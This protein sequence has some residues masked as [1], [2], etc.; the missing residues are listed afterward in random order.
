M[1]AGA[2]E[3]IKIARP[4]R[5]QNDR[6]HYGRDLTL[7]DVDRA[8]R[9]AA[10]GNML[11]IT[12][13]GRE[14]LRLDASTSGM[15]NKRLNRAGAIGWSVVANDGSGR[16]EYDHGRAKARA[17]FVRA[18]LLNIPH[19][20]ERLNDLRWSTW[21][22]RALHETRWEVTT[23]AAV[24][25]SKLYTGW[26]AAE[27]N[28]VHPRR[29]SFGQDRTVVVT[30]D[31]D[32]GSGFDPK[33]YRVQDLPEKFVVSTPRLFCDY[34]ELE[35]LSIRCQYWSF[36][37]RL[38][39]RERVAL[40]EIFAAPWRLAYSDGERPVNK[41]TMEAAFDTLVRMNSR[42]AAWLPHGTRAMFI[43]P[44]ASSGMTHKDVIDHAVAEL[45]K[46]IVGA[47]GTSDAISTG[48][49]SALGDVHLSEEDMIIATDLYML[50][51][52]IEHRLVSPIIELNY[53]PEELPYAPIFQFD[54][55]GIIDRDKAHDRVAKALEIGIPLPVEQVYEMLGY[56]QPR[57][58]EP[59][60]QKVLD[61]ETMGIPG[62]MPRVRI[63]YPIGGAPP[64]GELSMEPT[65]ALGG[66]LPPVSGALPPGP[67]PAPAP[68]LPPRNGAVPSPDAPEDDGTHVT[69]ERDPEDKK[70]KAPALPFASPSG[71]T[72]D[73]LED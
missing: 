40:M 20:R 13:L 3:K 66:A 32:P 22:N 39:A 55:R 1:V 5:K 51:D 38:S 63:V 8:L 34:P 12:D 44:D 67:A 69:D 37:K 24:G 62:A 27:L 17:E 18:Q 59:V 71:L 53:G 68:A 64:P 72:D 48:L 49:G 47:T 45:A 41:D 26:R 21:D 54:V 36:F 46:L 16:S 31:Y 58:G 6:T 60:L 11:M 33:G 14:T 70:R 25:D 30:N 65:E 42:N 43:Q 23:G 28:W 35:G 10:R 15:L 73:S 9:Q 50:A 57:D 56:R 19:F 2:L 7:D 4:S 52:V 61:P 29:L